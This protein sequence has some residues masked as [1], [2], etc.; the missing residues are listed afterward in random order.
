VCFP[1]AH[2]GRHLDACSFT[3]KEALVAV[4]KRFKAGGN[5]IVSV[6]E[7]LFLMPSILHHH[8]GAAC[9]AASSTHATELLQKNNI[10]SFKWSDDRLHA[11]KPLRNNRT[12]KVGVILAEKKPFESWTSL[13]VQTD[14]MI[15]S[16][17]LKPHYRIL[18]PESV[19]VLKKLC[20]IDC[21]V[22]RGSPIEDFLADKEYCI[23]L[24]S[25]SSYARASS[26]GVP[27]LIY[28]DFTPFEI[29]ETYSSSAGLLPEQP[30]EWYSKAALYDAYLEW[31]AQFYKSC[32]I[33]IGEIEALV[34]ETS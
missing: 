6:P 17:D 5:F 20:G 1:A 7:D 34:R 23:S 19:R 31:V 16:R 30:E 27:S 3:D 10:N 21:E 22:G 32:S 12:G 15:K 14:K 25:I 29:V 9:I 26:V 11:K 28:A 33:D 24:N 4:I 18:C 13:I 8:Y 2:L